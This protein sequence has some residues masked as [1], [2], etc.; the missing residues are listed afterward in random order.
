MIKQW[1]IPLFLL[2]CGIG[3]GPAFCSGTRLT[4]TVS[5][6]E[7]RPIAGLPLWIVTATTTAYEDYPP[8]A[9][10][11]PNGSFKI[12]GLTPGALDLH[13]CGEGYLQQSVTVRSFDEP[14]H[15]VL[16]PAATLSGRVVK[17]DGAP[18][19]EVEVFAFVRNSLDPDAPAAPWTPCRRSQWATTDAAGSFTAGPLPAGLYELR[20]KTD[21][22]LFGA[23]SDVRS[24]AGE[25]TEE[26]EIRLVSLRAG[27]LAGR[28]LDRTRAPIAGAHVTAKTET[29]YKTATSAADGSY[30]FENVGHGRITLRVKAP[31]YKGFE[32][33][34]ELDSAETWLDLF[35]DVPKIP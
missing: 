30:R 2:V 8:S 35:L 10:T 1:L 28:V 32:R 4:G 20:V 27:A 21:D 9:T 17:P 13:A 31:G 11:G 15:L 5:D 19:A 29:S 3:A 14:V 22:L 26:I 7:G 33:E 18:L 16:Q 6:P 12:L 25:V 23:V 34:T 24:A